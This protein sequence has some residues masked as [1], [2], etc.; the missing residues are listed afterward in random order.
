LTTLAAPPSPLG[1]FHRLGIDTGYLLVGFPISVAS[2]VVLVTGFAL[3]AGLLITLLGLPILAG[4]LRLAGW[5]AAL[6]RTHGAQVLGSPA[7]EA[8]C[9]SV[10]DQAGTVKR[11]LTVITDPRRWRETVYGLVRF[12]V[13]TLTWS[14]TITWWSLALTG[15]SYPLWAWSLP[16]VPT[17]RGSVSWSDLSV[18]AGILA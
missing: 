7:R 10:P 4:T 5:F 11:L 12:P 18:A 16:Q 17:T 9:R 2:F 13:A 14:L 3:G 1:L 8:S 15:L 6:E